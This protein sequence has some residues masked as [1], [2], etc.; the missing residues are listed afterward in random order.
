MEKGGI[1]VRISSDVFGEGLGVARQEADCRG[2]AE[3]HGWSVQ[4]VYIDNDVSAFSGKPRP[5]YRR[6]LDDIDSGRLDGVIAWHGDRLHRSPLELETFIGL[7]ETTGC[8]VATVQSGEL[9]L[10][11]PSGRLNARVVGSFARYESEHRSKRVRRKLEE[12]AFAGKHHGGSRPYGWQD[13][14]VTLELAEAA[15]VRMAIDMLLAGNSML[16]TVR[17]L[18]AAGARNTLGKA[19]T[20]SSLRPVVLRARNAGFRQHQGVTVGRGLWEPIVDVATYDRV[21]VL[22]T[23]PARRT[24]P[25]AAGRSRLLSGLARC[26]VCGAP[27]RAAKGKAY[28]GKAKDTYRCPSSSCV[29]RDLE[30][31]DGYIN[32][33][34]CRRL[35]RSDAVDLLRRDE[36]ESATLARQAVEDLRSRLDVAAA[37]YADDAITAQQLRTITARLHPRLLV[38]ERLV[39]ASR[40]DLQVLGDLVGTADIESVWQALDVSVRRQVIALLLTVTVQRARRGHG[41]FDDAAVSVEWRG[42]TSIERTV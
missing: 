13:D 40:P 38:A 8:Q 33:I 41:A 12:N 10:T 9:D 34:V 2:L 25:G 14:R 22:L 4:D 42:L 36:P 31:L 27:L 18:N 35:A 28:K 3:R 26:G 24:T 15:N 16:A 20:A 30:Q 11:T 23:D 37:D 32:T 19:W 7:I 6:L 17:A 39:P 29:T 21:R 5:S 1:Y